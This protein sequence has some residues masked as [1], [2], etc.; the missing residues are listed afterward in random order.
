M[1]LE[2]PFK[3]CNLGQNSI[4]FTGPASCN[5]LSN[6]LKVLNT[7]TLFTHN[8]KTLVLQNLIE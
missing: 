1:A 8:Y 5:K 2:I 6:N 4:S 3:K 7:A